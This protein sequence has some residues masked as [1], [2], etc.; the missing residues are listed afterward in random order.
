MP[1]L[2]SFIVSAR[3]GYRLHT[4]PVLLACTTL[5]CFALLAGRIFFAGSSSY[6]FMIWNL[7]LA[8]VPLICSRLLK[9]EMPP[10]RFWSLLG[11]WLLFFPNAPYVVTD[12]IHL[13]RKS[14]P[15]IPIWYDVAMLSNF[16]CLALLFGL[17]S[18][19][20]VHDVLERRLV[21]AKAAIVIAL[22]SFLSGFGIYL[23]R[24]LRWNSWDLF[25]RPWSLISDVLDRFID[26]FSHPRTWLVTVLFG[27][28]ILLL[29]SIGRA[30]LS[31]GAREI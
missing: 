10:W 9:A 15:T 12:L 2:R 14:H 31:Q 1:Q 29:H 16:A 8:F 4:L 19:R 21:P 13:H 17:I 26:P 7:F 27:G 11:L 22:V 3:R 6:S 30:V 24:F 20:K 25:T 5:W 23:G 18:L 28:T